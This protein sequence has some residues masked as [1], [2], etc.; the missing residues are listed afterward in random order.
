MQKRILFA[1]SSLG[2]GH[3]TR[4]LSVIKS[5]LK[6]N[7]VYILSDGKALK[8]LKTELGDYDVTYYKFKDYPPLERGSGLLFH[9]YLL[10]DSI[11]SMY[12]MLTKEKI[13]VKKLI[14]TEKINVIISDGRYGI[15]NSKIPSFLVTHQVE[16]QL[17]FKVFYLKLISNLLNKFFFSGFDKLLIPD[18]EDEDKNL[19]GMLSHTKWLKGHG[20]R[21]AGILSSYNKL[22]INEDIDYLFII[23]GFLDEQKESFLSR[24]LE[25]GKKLPGKKVFILGDPD[26]DFHKIDKE[27]NTEIYSSAA[28]ELRN[29]LFS[30]A[31]Y[32]ISR[33]GYTTIMDLVQMDKQALLI[34]TLNQSEQEYL[35]EYYREN[36]YFSIFTDQ[37][38]F[39]LEELIKNR[40][41]VKPFVPPHKSD[42]SVKIIHEEVNKLLKIK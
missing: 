1:I 34:P 35:A 28:G 16:Y 23:S 10:M 39:N 31:K 11:Y 40:I 12:L 21:F 27:Y 26:S 4:S 24:L 9:F 19:T 25:Q 30:R 38:N 41:K 13:F 42:I 32:I 5:F 17:P 29:E 2:L 6:D 37:V 18:Y 22:D 15:S 7:K 14:K 3:T 20:C 8:M 36:K 33:C